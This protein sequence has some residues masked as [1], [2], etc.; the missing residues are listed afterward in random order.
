M[1]H[2]RARCHLARCIDQAVADLHADAAD[3]LNESL[4]TLVDQ[5]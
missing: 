2:A 1:G 4:R 5:K 3:T